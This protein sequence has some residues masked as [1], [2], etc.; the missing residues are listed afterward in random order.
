VS[1]PNVYKPNPQVIL[2]GT[3]GVFAAIMACFGIMHFIPGDSRMDS[4]SAALVLSTM[5]A[6]LIGGAMFFSQAVEVSESGFGIESRKIAWSDI[7]EATT[8]TRMFFLRYIRLRTKGKRKRLESPVLFI[9]LHLIGR[10]PEFR[11]DILRHAPVDHPIRKC[12]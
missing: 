3:F 2:L 11:E 5:L 4:F 8:F 6:A 10:Y 9:P 12:I 7:E 1:K